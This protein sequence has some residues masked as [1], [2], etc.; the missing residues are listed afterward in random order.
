MENWKINLEIVWVWLKGRQTGARHLG[1]WALVGGKSEKCN[2]EGLILN[3][4]LYLCDSYFLY[5]MLNTGEFWGMQMTEGL[6]W[7]TET[8]K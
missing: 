8:W 6:E 1:D 4:R 3:N 7:I 2:L 5:R